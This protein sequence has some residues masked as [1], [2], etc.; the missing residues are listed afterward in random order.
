[1]TIS[2]LLLVSLK[3]LGWRSSK[4]DLKILKTKTFVSLIT[5]LV[6]STISHIRKKKKNKS[7]QEHHLNYLNN[8]NHLNQLSLHHTFTSIT[9][10]DQHFF[11]LFQ[12]NNKLFSISRQVFLPSTTI[13]FCSQKTN[14][15]TKNIYGNI[16]KN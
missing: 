12:P 1:M 16:Y 6:F 7:H 13:M 4:S 9:T 14:S 15:P 10:T 3:S 8:L 2:W 5:A 11:L